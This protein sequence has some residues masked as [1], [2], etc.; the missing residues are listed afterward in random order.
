MHRSTPS[1]R[2][3]VGSLTVVATIVGVFTGCAEPTSPARTVS[4]SAIIIIGGHPVLLNAEL[5]DVGNPD[6]KSTVAVAA[7]LQLKLDG[8]A[9]AGYVIDWK[10][11][12][13][14]LDREVGRLFGGGIYAIQDSEDFPSPLDVPLAYLIPPENPLGTPAGALA[15]SVGISE[16]LAARLIQDPGFFTAVFFLDGG[17]ALAGTLQLGGPATAPTR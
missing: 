17:G 6:I 5:R 8:T 7:H 4:P 12:L 14:N 11:D 15:G 2:R 1:K 9:L 16:E 10:V 3:V 13:A